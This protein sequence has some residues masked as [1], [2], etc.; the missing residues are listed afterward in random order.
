[1]NVDD[2]MALITSAVTAGGTWADLGAGRG[3]FTAALARLLGER[4]RVY[5]VDRDRA[6]VNVLRRLRLRDGDAVVNALDGD[7]AAVDFASRSSLRSLD[8]VLL[9]N[10]LHY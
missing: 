4:G 1:M 7:F 6:A 9:A 3:T 8:G 10:A 5:A 2:A